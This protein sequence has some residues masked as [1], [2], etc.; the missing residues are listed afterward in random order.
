MKFK[1][2]RQDL[3]FYVVLFVTFIVLSGFGPAACCPD[4]IQAIF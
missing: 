1:V 4:S 2:R 3:V